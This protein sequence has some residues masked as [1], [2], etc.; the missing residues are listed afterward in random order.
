MYSEEKQGW[1]L[2]QTWVE[3]AADNQG[4]IIRGVSCP[5]PIHCL[6]THLVLVEVLKTLMGGNQCG[7]LDKILRIVITVGSLQASSCFFV[8][9]IYT[10]QHRVEWIA[11][12]LRSDSKC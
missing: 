6:V 2:W 9:I 3:Y 7:E 4:G 5:I 11:F 1:D 8:H 12:S 10:A